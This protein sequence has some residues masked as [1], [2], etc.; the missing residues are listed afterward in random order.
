[1]N[2]KKKQDLTGMKFGRLTV[3]KEYPEKKYINGDTLWEC[4]CDCGS[5]K[6]SYS[7]GSLLR[8]GRK[9]SC[10]CIWKPT[11]EEYV[12]SLKLRLHEKS[13]W[14]GQCQEWTG[15]IHPSGYGKT[16]IRGRKNM[17]VHRLSWLIHIGNIP[18][19]MNV[20]HHC[21]NPLCFRPEHLFLGTIQ[22]NVTDKMK[23]KRHNTAR[24]DKSPHSKLR[25][26][27]VR[28]IFALKNSG[29]TSYDLT[30]RYNISASVIRSIWN[31]TSW[32]HIHDKDNL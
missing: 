2:K 12:A 24:G 18:E 4:I 27:Q 15:F 16:M 26:F 11:Q 8:R 25:E 22:D 31:K 30:Q 23:K 3:I 9:K 29:V 19:G 28:E 14:N 5:G 13:R 6:I 32:K 17:A 7:C 20:C 10:G 21:D 1:M